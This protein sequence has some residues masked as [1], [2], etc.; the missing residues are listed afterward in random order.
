MEGYEFNVGAL[1]EA[2]HKYGMLV[3]DPRW[4]YFSG[5]SQMNIRKSLIYLESADQQVRKKQ[6]GAT[7]QPTSEN[8]DHYSENGV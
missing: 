2:L 3:G 1:L 6:C 7:V 5:C 8:S 4:V